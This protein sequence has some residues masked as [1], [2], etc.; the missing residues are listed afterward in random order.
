[1]SSLFPIPLQ[2]RGSSE[3]ESL[4]SYIARVAYH[5]GT[6]IGDIMRYSYT[7]ANSELP[8]RREVYIKPEAILQAN[9]TTAYL[10]SS[11]GLCTGQDL[12]QGTLMCLSNSLGRSN[13]DIER[14][15]RWC[16]ECFSE[17]ESLG[18]EP[19]IK[20][21]WHLTCFSYCPNHFISFISACEHCGCDQTGYSRKYGIAMCQECGQSLSRRV[22]KIQ[23][24]N[25]HNSWEDNAFDVQKLFV[26]MAEAN[27]KTLQEGGVLKSFRSLV[28]WC[29]ENK[30]LDS[31]YSIIGKEESRL[32][33]ANQRAMSLTTIR[34]IAFK[35]EVPLF[36]FMNGDI[37]EHPQSLGL[38]I[39]SDPS[40]GFLEPKEKNAH[41]HEII[42]KKIKGSLERFDSPPTIKAVARSVGVSIGYIRYRYPVLL[43]EIV[44]THQDYLAKQQLHKIYI[45][46]KMALS[47]FMDEKYSVSPKSKRQA[48]KE[49]KRETGLAKGVIEQ[50]INRTYSA[51]NG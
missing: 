44:K 35:L 16:P 17:M 21:K 5:H 50:A 20:L 12:T 45:A 43:S 9:R 36:S 8:D 39:P 24:K 7:H 40:L 41:N 30:Q 1:M 48:Y 11:L 34:R 25:Y 2:G 46:Q 18:I 38:I 27:F 15:F 19:Y 10:A 26:D 14:G 31:L 28:H 33:A 23:P 4:P 42:L 6:S 37:L 49:V 3:V 13:H 47:Y 22:S 29:R 32:L 51:L